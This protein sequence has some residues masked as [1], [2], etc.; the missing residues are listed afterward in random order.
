MDMT[1]PLGDFSLFCT[2]ERGFVRARRVCAPGSEHKNHNI[3][4]SVQR[5]ESVAVAQNVG[6][7]TLAAARKVGNCKWQRSKSG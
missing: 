1:K 4:N 7:C 3:L 5:E 6:N 2:D